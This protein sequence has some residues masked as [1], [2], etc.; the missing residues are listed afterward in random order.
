M[1]RSVE[2]TKVECATN[3]PIWPQGLNAPEKVDK[4]PSTFELGFVYGSC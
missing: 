3:R 1:V 2:V 4:I